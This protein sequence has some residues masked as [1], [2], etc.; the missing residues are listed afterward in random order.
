MKASAENPV[1]TAYI[2]TKSGIRVNLDT[3]KTDIMLTHG[4]KDLAAQVSIRMANVNTKEGYLKSLLNVKDRIYVYA[5]D[6]SGAKEVFR[7]WL[8]VKDYSSD[9]EKELAF[10]CYDNLIYLQR[11]KDSFYF[12]SGKRTREAVQAICKKWGISLVYD[13]ESISHPKLNNFRAQYISDVIIDLLEEAKKQTGVPYV[14]YS[15]K[16]VMYVKRVGTNTTVYHLERKKNAL[17]TKSRVSLEDVV[18]KVV[19]TGNKDDIDR[20]P[21]L[22]SVEGDTATFGTLQE[23]ISK[24]KDTTIEEARK[25]ANEILKE[26]GKPSEEFSIASVD[27]PFLLKGDKVYVKSDD[28]DGYFIAKSVEHDAMKKTM[29]LDMERA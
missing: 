29:Y 23:M 16:D 25:E 18:T 5:N 6:G 24:D 27:I 15:D 20:D 11:S 10:S 13:Y 26:K 22:A 3:V 21:V 12:E 9:T 2:I 7:G 1:Y 28:L 17:Y 14:I 4:E 19:I 8:W